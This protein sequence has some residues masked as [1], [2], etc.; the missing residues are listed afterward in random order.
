MG[1]H[2]GPVNRLCK[3]V[4]NRLM[5]HLLTKQKKN[6]NNTQLQRERPAAYNTLRQCREE[7]DTLVFSLL[8][9]EVLDG[10]F[11]FNVQKK[12]ALCGSVY[13]KYPKLGY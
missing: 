2:N 7:D 12:K 13:K 8:L 1:F 11:I 5:L 6:N 9:F 4:S 3:Y 10:C